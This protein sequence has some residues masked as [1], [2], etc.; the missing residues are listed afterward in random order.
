[1]VTDLNI[2]EPSIN[3]LL[4]QEVDDDAV[5]AMSKDD[6]CALGLPIGQRAKIIKYVQDQIQA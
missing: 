4:S 6:W 3:L 2:A 1:M 5:A